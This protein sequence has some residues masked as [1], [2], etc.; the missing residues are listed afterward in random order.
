MGLAKNSLSIKP[1]IINI[2][3]ENKNKKSSIDNK[4]K[5]IPMTK[6][7]LRGSKEKDMMPSKAKALAP[8][9]EN[10]GLPA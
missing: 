4:D 7:N 8:K 5:I 6:V 10:L 9:K 3:T 1:I 2:F